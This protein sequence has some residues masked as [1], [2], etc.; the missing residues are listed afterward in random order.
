MVRPP[1]VE[2]EDRRRICRERKVLTSERIRH[3]NRIEAW[4]RPYEL[5]DLHEKVAS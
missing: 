2:D 5:I 4:D 1:S 3:E